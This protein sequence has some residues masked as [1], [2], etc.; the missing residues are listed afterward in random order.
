MASQNNPRYDAN[1]MNYR[2]RRQIKGY[3][4]NQNGQSPL[5]Q[6][7]AG[8]KELYSSG[9]KV[10][11]DG[12]LVP[13]RDF[14]G[15]MAAMSQQ[16]NSLS[17]SG[18][19]RPMNDMYLDDPTFFNRRPGGVE[20]FGQ[21]L[22][23]RGQ[24]PEMSRD[25]R[26]AEAKKSGTFGSIRSDF[27][28][29]A[30]SFGQMMSKT[31]EITTDPNK[32]QSSE[33]LTENRPVQFD[34]SGLPKLPWA[35]DTAESGQRVANRQ[36]LEQGA[37]G[38]KLQRQAS[39]DLPTVTTTGQGVDT[40]R[41]IEGKYGRG[42]A[43]TIPSSGA[44]INKRP[45]SEVMQG[46]ANKPGIAREGDTFQPQTGGDALYGNASGASVKSARDLMKGAPTKKPFTTAP[47][48]N[49]KQML[50]AAKRKP[51]ARA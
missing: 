10:G 39:G 9:M 3:S 25:Q 19:S 50:A 13:L 40:V 41:S 42:Q 24:Q 38:L 28:S 23:Q 49:G 4:Q 31:G 26:I 2:G 7:Q 21:M 48:N 22:A 29:K 20:R 12:N 15:T 16:R 30:K 17:P 33:W 8:A 44:T 46:L 11:R 35:G 47:M 32:P 43:A 45:F 36:A 14:G 34:K 6:A 37:A 18:G 1:G 5:S 27:N 51:L